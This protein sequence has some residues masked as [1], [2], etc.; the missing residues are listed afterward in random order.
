MHNRNSKNCMFLCFAIRPKSNF[1]FAIHG[2]CSRIAGLLNGVGKLQTIVSWTSL[3]SF[4]IHM[5]LQW[6]FRVVMTCRLA[7]FWDKI[8]TRNPRLWFHSLLWKLLIHNPINP[9][10]TNPDCGGISKNRAIPPQSG[11]LREECDRSG[12]D[13]ILARSTN[14]HAIR[15]KLGD[16]GAIRNQT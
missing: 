9:Q 15:R 16:F 10:S 7:R 1:Y 11:W 8:L 14:P 13:A 2:D 3:K 6:D 5:R 12:I 4:K